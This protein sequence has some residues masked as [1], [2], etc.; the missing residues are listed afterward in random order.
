MLNF[1]HRYMRGAGIGATPAA[2]VEIQGPDVLRAVEDMGMLLINEERA[3]RGLRV[4]Q[5][6]VRLQ[7]VAKAHSRDMATREYCSHFSPE[8]AGPVSRIARHGLGH[9]ALGEN[10]ALT[11]LP[12]E[13]QDLA[14]LETVVKEAHIGFMNSPGHRRAILEPKLFTHACVGVAVVGNRVGITQLFIRP[15]QSRSTALSMLLRLIRL[16]LGGS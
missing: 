5:P 16:A 13:P 15:G 7:V 10:V 8:G 14:E 9:R 6:D 1:D 2:T 12:H 11:R 3:A 4:Y